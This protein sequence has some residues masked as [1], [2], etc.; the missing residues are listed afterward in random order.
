MLKVI[1]VVATLVISISISDIPKTLDVKVEL[2]CLTTNESYDIVIAKQD[3]EEK[4]STLEKEVVR[5][6]STCK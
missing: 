1:S 2:I 3:L 5:F 6:D 4:Y